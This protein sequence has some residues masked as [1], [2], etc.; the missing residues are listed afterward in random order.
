MEEEPEFPSACGPIRLP[1]S[2][3]RVTDADE[4]IF[5]LYTSLAAQ[6][7]TDSS[8]G[9]RGLGYVDSHKDTLTIE[10]TIQTPDASSAIVENDRAIPQRRLGR[11][12]T[13]KQKVAL[14]GQEQVLS[15][16]LYQDKTALRSRKGDTGSVLWRASVDLAH[17]VLQQYYA[18]APD[19]LISPAALQGAHVLELG[20]GTG[21]LA[22]VLSRIVARYTATDIEAL[23]PLIR[24]NLT[25]NRPKLPPSPSPKHR[26]VHSR[27]DTAHSDLLANVI[28]EALDWEMLHR[29][30]AHARRSLYKFPP[31]DI[32]LVVDCI[33]HPSLLP[34]LLSTID[35]LTTPE[36]TAV[37]VVTEL[38]AEDVVRE[39]LERWL[40][41]S[42][43]GA[44]KVFRVDGI[45]DRPYV[46]WIGWKRLSVGQE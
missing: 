34:A 31:I 32:L 39:F 41:L 4:E 5:L 18:R 15:V 16:E 24:K 6:D 27:G 25:L 7:P 22:I 40:A 38:R 28:V 11:A 21:L 46:I 2:T 43:E 10:F 12:A 44:W 36:L 14:A 33:Y 20:T 13:K 45:L 17:Y 19:A 35:H 8:T 37:L 1:P 23:V 26:R 3:I 9:F 29:A 30:S 42:P